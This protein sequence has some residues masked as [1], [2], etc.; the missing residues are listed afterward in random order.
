MTIL[1]KNI[2]LA[3]ALSSLRISPL[4]LIRIAII[5]LLYAAALYVIY[6]SVVYIQ[7]IGSGIGFSSG[8]FQ[9]DFSSHLLLDCSKSD[10]AGLALHLLMSALLPF[11]PAEESPSR[12]RLT[13]A[14]QSQFTLSDELTEIL[15]G[16]KLGDLYAEKQ[17]KNVR[18][19]FKQGIVHEDYLMHLYELFQNFCPSVPKLKKQSA[20]LRTGKVY[21]GI[22][23]NTYS[24]PCSPK[25][26]RA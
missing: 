2:I 22:Y 18:L 23:F 10:G 17:T 15:V 3:I 16:L 8:L 24:L 7:S 14:E 12:H 9:D 5:V 26:G 6:L 25:I 11:K 20:D 1:F 21:V 4:L 13:K 19:V